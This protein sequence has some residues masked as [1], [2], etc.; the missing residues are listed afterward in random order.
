MRAAGRP[1]PNTARPPCTRTLPAEDLTARRP[2]GCRAPAPARRGLAAV[3]TRGSAAAVPAASAPTL[4]RTRPRGPAGEG[5]PRRPA[6]GHQRPSGCRSPDRARCGPDRG[7]RRMFADRAPAAH[8][9]ASAP[10]RDAPAGPC[11]TIT[12]PYTLARVYGRS[13]PGRRP[14]AASTSRSPAHQAGRRTQARPGCAR[15]RVPWRHS[16]PACPPGSPLPRSV[17]R[18]ASGRTVAATPAAVEQLRSQDRPA[19][20]H[21]HPSRITGIPGIQPVAGRRPSPRQ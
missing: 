6:S 1:A 8:R 2:A 12:R 14:S 18:P 10:T 21:P 17:S 19:G 4:V 15:C 5:C 16:S 20:L 3:A 7:H 9:A 11:S 13:G